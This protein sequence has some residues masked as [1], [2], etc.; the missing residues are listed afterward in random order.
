MCVCVCVVCVCVCV[1][2]YVCVCVCVCE[3]EGGRE[4]PA[5]HFQEHTVTYILE[6]KSLSTQLRPRSDCS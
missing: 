3:R 1:C 5:H 4:N 2:V 6:Q